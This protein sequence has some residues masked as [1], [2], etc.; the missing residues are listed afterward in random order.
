[1]ICTASDVLQRRSCEA[2]AAAAPRI[3][4]GDL[5]PVFGG[6]SS[7]SDVTLCRGISGSKCPLSVITLLF[8]QVFQRESQDSSDSTQP[9]EPFT[10]LMFTA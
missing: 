5:G 3:R 4:P 6:K 9:I 10:T 2:F 8:V 1:M 7:H